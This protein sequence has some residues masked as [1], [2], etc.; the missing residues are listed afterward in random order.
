MPLHMN[1]S[2]LEMQI[3]PV[4]LRAL[5]AL[6]AFFHQFSRIIEITRDGLAC[7][8]LLLMKAK[9]YVNPCGVLPQHLFSLARLEQEGRFMKAD[10]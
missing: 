8:A 10:H 9:D 4:Q 7:G 5:A 2:C 6:F 3:H 1:P